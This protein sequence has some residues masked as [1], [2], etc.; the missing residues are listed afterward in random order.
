M[1]AAL[2]AAVVP[3]FACGRIGF[4]ASGTTDAADAPGCIAPSEPAATRVVFAG[5]D[6]FAILQALVPG[7]VVEVHAGIYTS[8]GVQVT[9]S[10]TQAQPIIVRA[11]PGER[12]VLQGNPSFNLFDLYGS[13]FTLRGFELTGADIGIRL[14][15]TDHGTLDDLRLHAL[16]NEGLT[17]NNVNQPC[18]AMT[19]RRLEIFGTMG[20]GTGIALGCPDGSCSPTN[21]TVE[22][23]F[24]HDLG[25]TTGVAIFADVGASALAIRDN[26]IVRVPGPGIQTAGTTLGTR[27]TIERNLV[28]GTTQDNGIQ[29]EGQVIVRNNIVIGAAAYGIY[30]NQGQLPPD[31]AEIVHNT[32]IGLGGESGCFKTNNWDTSTGQIVAN[33]AF[34]CPASVAVDIA[35]GAPGAVFANNIVLGSSNAPGGVINGASMAADLGDPSTAMVYPPT[36]S[37]MIDAGD[38][39][40]TAGDDFNGLIRAAPPDVG[41][42]EHTTAGNPGWRIVEGFKPLPVTGCAN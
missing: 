13:W 4:D 11:A 19:L 28:Y 30:S 15:G 40:H 5:E 41:A 39:A 18:V 37:A 17:C 10:G 27:T 35:A 16:T 7:D 8:P 3:A 9:W 2:L 32:V 25:G 14:H 21:T 42:Y 12:P 23:C 26:V 24:I 34:Y 31:D 1:R 6:L 20:I 38:P 29:I 36:G 33:N 22:G